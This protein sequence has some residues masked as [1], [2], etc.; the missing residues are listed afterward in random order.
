MTRYGE[1]EAD[2]LFRA[3]AEADGYLEPGGKGLWAWYRD[4]GMMPPEVARKVVVRPN[5]RGNR[6]G[7]E[8]T[9]LDQD[10]PFAR[11][12]RHTAQQTQGLEGER[13]PRFDPAVVLRLPSESTGLAGQAR[14]QP[15]R[16]TR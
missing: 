4:N 14:P 2:D 5:N 6:D 16:W 1:T 9:G 15:D 12:G 3:R 7:R 13:V 11:G 8:I 10:R